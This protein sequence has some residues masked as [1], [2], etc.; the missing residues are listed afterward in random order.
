LNDGHGRALV[1][2]FL[3]RALFLLDAIQLQL[4]T[5]E[6]PFRF[7]TFVEEGVEVEGD[8]VFQG[9]SP[10]VSELSPALKQFPFGDL[11]VR[12]S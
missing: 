10:D 5:Q 8:R 6:V 7:Q 9:L 11:V 12:H 1:G 3:A 4:L 2:V